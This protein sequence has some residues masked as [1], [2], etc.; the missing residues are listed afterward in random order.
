MTEDVLLPYQKAWIEDESNEI[1]EKE[2]KSAGLDEAAL[3][4][5]KRKILGI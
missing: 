3:E 2:A 5:I 1:V 4:I